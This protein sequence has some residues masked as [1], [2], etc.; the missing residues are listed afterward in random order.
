MDP[1]KAAKTVK[2]LDQI[3]Q[4]HPQ[5]VWADIYNNP[6]A[7]ETMGKAFYLLTQ[8]QAYVHITP[9]PKT[10][11]QVVEFDALR[12]KVQMVLSFH[13]SPQSLGNFLERV[14]QLPIAR[15][16]KEDHHNIHSVLREVLKKF[17]VTLPRQDLVYP[18]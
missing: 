15:H 8:G 2:E 6:D 12:D 4:N 14:N 1:D 13:K 9:S 18:L 7:V 10:A 17:D 5:N 16:V 3:I 11:E